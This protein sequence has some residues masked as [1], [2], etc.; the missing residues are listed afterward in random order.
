ME[1][2]LTQNMNDDIIILQKD[3]KNKKYDLFNCSICKQNIFDQGI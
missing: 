2:N 1:A 3:I